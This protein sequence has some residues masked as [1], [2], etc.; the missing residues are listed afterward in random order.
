MFQ[1]KF[2]TSYIMK[3]LL[4]NMCCISLQVDLSEM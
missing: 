1:Q 3:T 4:E 2:K